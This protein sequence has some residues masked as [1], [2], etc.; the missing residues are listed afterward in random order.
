MKSWKFLECQDISTQCASCEEGLCTVLVRPPPGRSRVLQ[1]Q[2]RKEV[3]HSAFKT[4]SFSCEL[5][6]LGSTQ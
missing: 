6:F 3:W 5:S 1:G 4:R 2:S